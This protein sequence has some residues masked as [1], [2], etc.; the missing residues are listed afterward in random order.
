[1][2]ILSNKLAENF[3]CLTGDE[4]IMKIKWMDRWKFMEVNQALKMDADINAFEASRWKDKKYLEQT[5]T[6]I[7]GR[8]I[9]LFDELK[10]SIVEAWQHMI[11]KCSNVR[12]EY[13]HYTYT[14]H[15]DIIQLTA[16][17]IVAD[18]DFANEYIGLIQITMTRK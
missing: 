3:R 5:I 4:W 15:D 17:Q 7:L 16:S 9:E 14:N 1:M 18:D 6:K 8:P 10:D 13:L 11:E 12:P 2:S